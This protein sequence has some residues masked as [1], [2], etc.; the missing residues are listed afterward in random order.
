MPRSAVIVQ[1]IQSSRWSA[2]ERGGRTT[3]PSAQCDRSVVGRQQQ[4]SQRKSAVGVDPKASGRTMTSGGSSRRRAV[5]RAR[6][7]R[8]RIQH[9][10][11]DERRVVRREHTGRASARC[12]RSLQQVSEENSIA[13]SRRMCG[14]GGGSPAPLSRGNAIRWLEARGTPPRTFF[15]PGF[16]QFRSVVGEDLRERCRPRC[17]RR[18]VRPPARSPGSGACDDHRQYLPAALRASALPRGA[19][20]RKRAILS[21]RRRRTRRGQSHPRRGCASPLPGDRANRGAG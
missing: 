17:A 5:L 3:S 14:S 19:Q 8:V 4:R 9:R 16:A 13:R 15:P 21:H 6:G 2:T 20:G 18:K 11:H 1:P 7:A 12:R 10:L